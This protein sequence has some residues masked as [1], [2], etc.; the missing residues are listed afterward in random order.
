[1]KGD[2]NGR[3]GN[4]RWFIGAGS[5]FVWFFLAPVEKGGERKG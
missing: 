5:E 3:N 4:P 2:K 1:M